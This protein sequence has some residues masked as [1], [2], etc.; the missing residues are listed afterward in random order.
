MKKLSYLI[1]KYISEAKNELWKCL[2]CGA[3]WNEPD[4]GSLKVC[5]KCGNRGDLDNKKKPVMKAKYADMY[6]KGKKFGAGGR[7]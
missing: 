2:K 4:D 3:K 1:E 7:K 6:P 5:P